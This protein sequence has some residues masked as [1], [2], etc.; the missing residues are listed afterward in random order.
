MGLG[1]ARTISN[2]LA[3]RMKSWIDGRVAEVPA[4][5]LQTA[6]S[7]KAKTTT[8]ASLQGARCDGVAAALKVGH[9]QEDANVIHVTC[10]LGLTPLRG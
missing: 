7:Q 6:I 5:G 3:L 10:L 4:T 9:P 1:G 2:L 8:V